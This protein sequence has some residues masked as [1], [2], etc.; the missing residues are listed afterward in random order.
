MSQCRVCKR[1]KDDRKG[2]ICPNVAKLGFLLQNDKSDLSSELN[3]YKKSF[4]ELKHKQA[5]TNDKIRRFGVIRN[6]RK[7]YPG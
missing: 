4:S 5:E 2:R 6:Y 3:L 7:Y 1:I